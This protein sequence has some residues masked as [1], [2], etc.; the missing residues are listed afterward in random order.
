MVLQKK[1]TILKE[2]GRITRLFLGHVFMI[3][4]GTTEVECPYTFLQ[5]PTLLSDIFFKCIS[6][7]F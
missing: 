2:N 5:S 6:L 7:L 1:K 3:F 4:C